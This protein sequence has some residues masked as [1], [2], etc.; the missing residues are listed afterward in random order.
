MNERIHLFVIAILA[1]LTVSACR[2]DGAPDTPRSGVPA[3][4]AGE[5][6]TGTLSTIQ[7]YNRDNG[8][9]LDPSGEGFYFILDPDGF[10]ETG[11][12]ITSTVAGCTMRL[13]GTEVGTVV[14]EGDEVTVHRH[15]VKTHVTNS[16]GNSGERTQGQETRTMWWSVE[17]DSSG[18]EWLVL[19]HGDGTSERY[20]RWE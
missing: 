15:W 11:A 8:E 4:I 5:W 13:L 6:F 18:V 2:D 9:W 16:C 17:T 3:E 19:D 7:Y 12:V 14:I 1:A 10:Y 20:H